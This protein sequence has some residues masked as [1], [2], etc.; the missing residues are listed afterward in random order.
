MLPLLLDRDPS[1]RFRVFDACAVDE[2][3]EFFGVEV[4]TTGQSE[5]KMMERLTSKNTE[6]QL[7]DAIN[8]WN[9]VAREESDP[10]A[11]KGLILSIFIDDPEGGHFIARGRWLNTP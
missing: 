8:T 11:K 6:T 10:L 2:D 9:N 5:A 4:K 3:G 1:K 7:L